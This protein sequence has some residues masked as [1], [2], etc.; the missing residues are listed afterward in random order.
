MT[1]S[2]LHLIVGMEVQI[3]CVGL[4]DQGLLVC[5][6]QDQ[7]TPIKQHVFCGIRL[8]H[9]TAGA[10]VSHGYSCSEEDLLLTRAACG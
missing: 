4:L 2:H 9:S 3:D 7:H 6:W 1:L 10:L 8:S 5:V